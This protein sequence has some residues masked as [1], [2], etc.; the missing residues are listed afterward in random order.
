MMTGLSTNLQ[1]IS[2]VQTTAIIN[3]ELLCLQIDITPLQETWLAE[4]GCLRE[5]D[6]TF[7]W[8]GKKKKEDV[9]EH[10]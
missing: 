9:H 7:F 1:T 5:S 4:S 6:Y 3:N 8:Q 10:V 2:D